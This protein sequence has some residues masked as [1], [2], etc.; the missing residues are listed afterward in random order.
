[1]ETG[2][3]LKFQVNKEG[4]DIK[5]ISLLEDNFEPVEDDYE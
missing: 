3:N 1:M 5:Y 4:I 2:I